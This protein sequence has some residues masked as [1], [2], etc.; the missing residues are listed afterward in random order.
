MSH[1]IKAVK[2]SILTELIYSFNKIAIK[3]LAEFIS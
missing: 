3:L 2:I 1:G